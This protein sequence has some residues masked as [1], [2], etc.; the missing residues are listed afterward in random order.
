M[1]FK[2]DYCARLFKHK[3]SRDRHTKVLFQ[4]NKNEKL[5]FIQFIHSFTLAIGDTSAYIVNQLFQ[6][7]KRF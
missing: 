1:P 4:P 2:C 6:E 7:G 3:R 5:N